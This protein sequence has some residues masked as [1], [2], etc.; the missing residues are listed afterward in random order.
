MLGLVCGSFLRFS[1]IDWDHLRVVVLGFFP[2]YFGFACIS[3]L[4][5]WGCFLVSW[6]E[7]FFVVWDLWEYLLEIGFLRELGF[8]CA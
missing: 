6:V 5:F 2:L 7:V 3:G 4:R 8:V 1:V